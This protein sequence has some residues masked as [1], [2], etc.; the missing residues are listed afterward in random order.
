MDRH[1]LLVVGVVV[2]PDRLPARGRV[3]LLGRAPV[4]LDRA[5]GDDDRDARRG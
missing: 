2:D 1:D 5:V 3:A 4:G